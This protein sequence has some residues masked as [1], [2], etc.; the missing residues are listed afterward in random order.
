VRLSIL[1]DKNIFVSAS[2]KRCLRIY[3][4]TSNNRL[5]IAIA[6]QELAGLWPKHLVKTGCSAYSLPI[7]EL[8]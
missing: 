2:L 8:R 4:Q 7:L 6:V 5:S 3:G 1:S